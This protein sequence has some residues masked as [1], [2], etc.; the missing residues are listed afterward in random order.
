MTEPL[1]IPLDP[2]ED[3]QLLLPKDPERDDIR[4]QIGD[5]PLF[6]FVLHGSTLYA[7][8]KRPRRRGDSATD[9]YLLVSVAGLIRSLKRAE[10]YCRMF[11]G[12]Q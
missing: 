6:D 7:E 10:Q 11:S 9:R 12:R 2:E 8:F 4:L 5:H 3:L 1:K